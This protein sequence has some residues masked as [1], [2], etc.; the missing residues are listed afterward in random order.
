M[1]F[2][3]A[4]RT[5]LQKYV[6]FSGRASRPEYWYFVL[7]MVLG[8]ILLGIADNILFNT[9]HVSRGAGF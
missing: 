1:D 8:Q 9:G 4:V 7:F 2:Q 5:C 6:T 3:T